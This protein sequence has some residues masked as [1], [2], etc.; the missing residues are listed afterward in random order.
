MPLKS[1]KI[2]IEYMKTGNGATLLPPCGQL[3][4]LH[5]LSI[6]TF[7]IFPFLSFYNHKLHY[8][9]LGFYEFDQHKMV[10]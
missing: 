9:S 10:D 8:I 6:H 5:S 2:V 7:Y 1:P 4:T 3:S